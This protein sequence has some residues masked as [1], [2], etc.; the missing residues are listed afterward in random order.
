MGLALAM[1]VIQPL[2]AQ[3]VAGSDE[4]KLY[5]QSENEK[6][7]DKK[8][9]LLL[10]FEK[11][12]PKSPVLVDVEVSLMEI[13]QQKN[14]PAKTIE[15]GEKA[16]KLDGENVGTL[17]AVAREYALQKKNLDRAL[18]YAQKAVDTVVKMKS[19]QPPGSYSPEQ[20]KQY[21]DSTETNARGILAYVKSIG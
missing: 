6:N 5:Q 2:W 20:W 21:I 3:L 1:A 10:S 8:L 4:D 7:P 18:A 19:Q 11:T 17:L 14:D 12:F 9:Q 13:Y 16:I 15:Y